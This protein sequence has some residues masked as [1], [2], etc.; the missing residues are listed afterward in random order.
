[1][2]SPGAEATC[3]A[4]PNTE[5]YIYLLFLGFGLN[6]QTQGVRMYVGFHNVRRTLNYTKRAHTHAHAWTH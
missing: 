4:V 3:C 5:L 2:F 1:M 6:H